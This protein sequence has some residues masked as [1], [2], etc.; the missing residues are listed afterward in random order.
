MV[1]ILEIN[2]TRIKNMKNMN[3]HLKKELQHFNNS[4]GNINTA[5][6]QEDMAKIFDLFIYMNRLYIVYEFFEK[7]TLQELVC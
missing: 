5:S 2:L 1:S 7:G 3:M 4:K 6:Y